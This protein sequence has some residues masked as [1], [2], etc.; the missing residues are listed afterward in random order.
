MYSVGPEGS[1]LLD[2]QDQ[3]IYSDKPEELEDLLWAQTPHKWDARTLDSV[4]ITVDPILY[5]TLN[6]EPDAEILQLPFLINS[7][8]MSEEL[9]EPCSP[10]Q[11]PALMSKSFLKSLPTLIYSELLNIG[12]DGCLEMLNL[13]SMYNLRMRV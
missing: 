3:M 7:P 11:S 10:S 4:S 8:M 2:L 13:N 12:C 6:G 1:T 9:N 5:L